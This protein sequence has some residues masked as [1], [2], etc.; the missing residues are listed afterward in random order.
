VRPPITPHKAILGAIAEGYG[1]KTSILR[2]AEW[3]LATDPRCHCTGRDLRC[4]WTWL[5]EHGCIRRQRGVWE[6]S[7]TY[8]EVR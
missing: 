5:V 3:T 6:P 8:V 7:R 1:V 4:A 2:Q